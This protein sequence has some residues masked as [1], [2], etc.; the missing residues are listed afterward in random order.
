M[1]SDRRAH[2]RAFLRCERCTLVTGAVRTSHVGAASASNEGKAGMGWDV[3]RDACV[4][5][6]RPS[7][8]LGGVAV[9]LDQVALTAARVLWWWETGGAVPEAPAGALSGLR[10][11]WGSGLALWR[12]LS[13]TLG[14]R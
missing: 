13:W 14:C 5:S 6:L 11:V 3:Q 8:T 2:D 10:G 1:V 4:H 7:M 9:G 12:H